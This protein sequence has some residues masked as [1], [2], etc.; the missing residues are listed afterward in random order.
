MLTTLPGHQ[1]GLQPIDFD[2]PA[3]QVQEISKN[4]GGFE[5]VRDTSFAVERGSLL[6]LLGPSGGG[7]TT[8][9]RLIAGFE[10]P[11]AG[12]IAIDGQSIVD[13]KHNTP[14][15]R[16]RVGMVFQDYALFPHLTVRQNVAFGVPRG[17]NRDRSVDQV[18]DMVG[19]TD[20]ASRMPHQLSGGQQQR[21]ALA[22]ALA[23]NPS[24]VLLDEPFSNL[25]AALRQRVR[26]EVRQI[27]REA[28]TTAIFVTHDQ[29]EAFGLADCVGVMLDNTIVQTGTPEEVYLYP[30]T[31]SVAEFLGETNTLEGTYAEGQVECELG[32][33]PVGG[34]HPRNGRV[35]VSVRPE[36][37]R[38]QPAI[39]DTARERSVPDGNLTPAVITSLEFRGVYK[40]LTL[41]LPSGL[42]LTAVMGLHVHGEVG[43]EVHLSVNSFVAAFPEF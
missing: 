33:L 2:V 25:D 41:R 35:K 36:T 8:T 17:S 14:P 30:A 19:L 38:L 13:A 23:P 34:T 32:R 9:L 39:D 42:Q 43:E 3:V 1:S 15:E 11:D 5:A 26:E 4:F 12:T 28:N 22:R 10:T 6:A 27:L 40:V 21:V 7:K 24:V 20:E 18:L 16:R 31:L 37:I 29:D